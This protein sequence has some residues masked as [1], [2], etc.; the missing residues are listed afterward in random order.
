MTDTSLAGDDLPIATARHQQGANFSIEG[1][2]HANII[3]NISYE[4]KERIPNQGGDSSPMPE[5]ANIND[6][7]AR[8]LKA[9]MEEKGFQSQAKLAEKAGVDQKTISNYLNPAQRLEGGTAGKPRSAKL[10]EVESIANALGVEVWEL[11][12]PLETA[13]RELFRTIRKALR[14]A[15]EQ[16]ATTMEGR[17]T[18]QQAVMDARGASRK[19]QKQPADEPSTPAAKTT[20][21]GHRPAKT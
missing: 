1:V 16:Q 11:L 21:K 15:L 5:N 17:R 7:L 13:E 18:G 3:G 10:A 9:I 12:Q 4:R 19:R 20:T 6:V 8:N 2:F 14:S